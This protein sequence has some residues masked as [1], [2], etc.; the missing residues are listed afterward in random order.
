V[1]QWPTIFGCDVA[2]TVHSVG[3]DVQGFKVGDRVIGCV[4]FF[5]T[6][7]DMFH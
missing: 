6:F 3:S 4:A 7:L 1:T 2:G 5:P